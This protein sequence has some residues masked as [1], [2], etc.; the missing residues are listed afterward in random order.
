MRR[1]VL[2]LFAITLA[3]LP[4]A[5]QA[6]SEEVKLDLEDMPV[7]YSLLR[8]RSL[9]FPRIFK[10]IGEFSGLQ[11]EAVKYSELKRI[12]DDMDRPHAERFFRGLRIF[13][14]LTEE[15]KIV[16][17]YM[18]VY[19]NYD[20]PMND[21][22]ERFTLEENTGDLDS[23]LINTN[24][25]IY[26]AYN[27]LLFDV[28]KEE[29]SYMAA[30][31]NSSRYKRYVQSNIAFRDSFVRSIFFPF[32]E[33]DSL[34]SQNQNTGFG[35]KYIHLT[36]VAVADEAGVYRHLAY[37]ST[38]PPSSQAN[39]APGGGGIFVS[40]AANMAHVCPPMCRSVVYEVVD[41]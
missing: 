3:F 9:D 11:T 15:N 10:G 33:V 25:P 34:Y 30:L 28:R 40:M 1:L 12:K 39:S 23:A 21:K 36:S 32:Q 37:M 7:T 41:K 6:Q 13:P 2:F 4:G 24:L 22:E 16:L 18:P 14:G 8:T 38:L 17:Y 27:Y 31:E 5:V 35:S 19:A 29:L 20:S 26:H